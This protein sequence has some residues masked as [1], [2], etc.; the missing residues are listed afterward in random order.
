MS[1][2]FA[3]LFLSFLSPHPALSAR[4]SGDGKSKTSQESLSHQRV[5][6]LFFFSLFIVKSTK[7]QFLTV[8]KTF[9]T[10]S[11][12]DGRERVVQISVPVT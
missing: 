12:F 6:W 8:V 11:V 2:T 9:S 3:S 10:S 4:P 5:T 7:K 1:L